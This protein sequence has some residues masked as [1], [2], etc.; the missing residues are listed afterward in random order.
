MSSIIS[1]SSS[2]VTE[3]SGSLLLSLAAVS[4]IFASTAEKGRKRPIKKR[5]L[6]AQA[7]ASRSGNFLAMLFGSISP[8]KNTSSVV[9]IVL[10]VTTESPQRRVTTMVTSA[11]INR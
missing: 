10:T 2:S 9:R 6:P 5:R 8:A 11:E 4:P 7:F 1:Y 3:S